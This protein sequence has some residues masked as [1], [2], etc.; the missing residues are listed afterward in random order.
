VR[1]ARHRQRSALPLAWRSSAPRIH[2][3]RPSPPR[4]P[5][6]PLPAL[7]DPSIED[8]GQLPRPLHRDRWVDALNGLRGPV[9]QSV[10]RQLKLSGLVV[11]ILLGQTGAT[12]P[13]G[14]VVLDHPVGLS[15]ITQ[16]RSP[17][18]R[19]TLNRPTM[20]TESHQSK[21]R[22]PSV[23]QPPVES[24]LASPHPGRP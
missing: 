6:D 5:A 11:G 10:V 14:G 3:I 16:S 15:Q 9:A 8:A 7:T 1:R 17:S 24:R 20:T 18:P 2:T 23:C 22:F 13:V 4:T 19:R 12:L 21:L